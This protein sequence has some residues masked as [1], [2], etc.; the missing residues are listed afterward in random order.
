MS[1]ATT[2]GGVAAPAGNTV[3]GEMPR[4]APAPSEVKP[5]RSETYVPPTQLTVLPQPSPACYETAPDDY[6]EE[7]LNLQIEGLVRIVVT[8]D[9]KGSIVEARP[10]DDPGHGLGAAAVAALRRHGCTFTP[11]RKGSEPIATRI[12]FKYRFTLP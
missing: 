7:A 4:T 1:S 10:L 8:L 11:G 9:E 6:P 2:S 3:Y 5:Y 12:I